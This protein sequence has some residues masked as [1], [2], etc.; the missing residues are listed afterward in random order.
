MNFA[1]ERDI[2][3]AA[4]NAGATSKASTC[5]SWSFERRFAWIFD[6]R[7]PSLNY[8]QKDANLQGIVVNV[9]PSEQV[10]PSNIST[11]PPI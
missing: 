3:T 5:E 1:T 6:S 10:W 11:C 7:E 8:Q 9:L 2:R 4:S